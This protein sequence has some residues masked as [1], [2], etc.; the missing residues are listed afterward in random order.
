MSPSPLSSRAWVPLALVLLAALALAAPASAQSAIPWAPC[1]TAGYECATVPVPLDRTNLV[2]GTVAL[3]VTRVPAATNPRRDAVVALAGGPGQAA[4][5][6]AQEFAT[7]LKPAITDRDLLV[8]DQRGTGSSGALDCAA[9]HQPVSVLVATASCANQIGAAR[10][11]YRT[12]DSV[13]DIEA[14]RVAGGYDKLVLVGVSYGTKVAL[15]YAAAHPDHVES[16][17]LDSVVL[18]EGPDPFQR[19][20][21]ADSTRVLTD[22]CAADACKSST[23]NVGRDLA[24]VAAKL[25]AK[26]LKGKVV[27]T[28]GG[29]ASYSMDQVGLLDILLAGDLNPTLRAELP[30]SLSA[31]LTGDPAPLLRLSVRSEGLTTGLQEVA[32]SD[33]DALFLATMCEES[34]FPWTREAGVQQRN[35]EALAAAKTIP[36]DQLGPFSADTALLGGP[37]KFCLGWPDASPAPAPPGAL[38]AVPTLVIDGGLDLRTP[39]EDAATLASRIPTATLLKVPYSGHSVLS[40]DLSACSSAALAAFFA[41]TPIAPCTDATNPFA[42]TAKPP[43]TLGN[44][45]ARTKRQRTL[46]AAIST[47]TDARR[48]VIGDA[49][50]IGHLPSRI[51]G[52]R[53]GNATV[54]TSAFHLHAYQYVTGVRVSGTADLQGNAT[55]TLH[56]GGALSG[57]LK[58]GANGSVSGKLGG[59]KITIAASSAVKAGLPSLKSVLARPHLAS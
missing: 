33:S 34:G 14:L 23:T 21:L 1:P 25:N 26:P 40:S 6:L 36:R 32:T 58:V 10:G 44:V 20:T 8:F 16:L 57:R 49:Y 27:T 13:E 24:R 9:L 5:P 55:I 15:A 51:A 37:I 4:V 12:S 3:S 48:Q 2:P 38:P 53:G 18:P 39:Y 54:S 45:K 46:I 56:G 19:S 17:V 30:G 50:A 52:L 29:R 11:F 28:S 31:A 41:A 47:V 42:P 35:Q 43:R 22:L 59:K 7:L